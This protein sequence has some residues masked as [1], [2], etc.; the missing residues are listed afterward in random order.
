MVAF[1]EPMLELFDAIAS[2]LY[3]IRAGEHNKTSQLTDRD[4]T[5][6]ER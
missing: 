6:E 1:R 5:E 2:A 4:A 3:W